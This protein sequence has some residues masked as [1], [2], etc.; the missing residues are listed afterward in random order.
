MK[1][2]KNPVLLYN[3]LTKTFSL[4]QPASSVCGIDLKTS[5]V[6]FIY[7]EGALMSRSDNITLICFLLI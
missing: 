6:K 1:T 4:D 3:S 2:F 7:R 5:W